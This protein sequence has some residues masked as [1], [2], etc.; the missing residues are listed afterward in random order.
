M[1]EPRAGLMVTT[2]VRLVRPLGEGGMGSVWVAEHTGLHT[3]VVVK[4]ISKEFA[5][6]EEA[7]TRFS[8]EA[9]AASQVK[10]PH[11]VQTLDHGVT[12]D[13]IA[14]IVMEH[15]EGHDLEAHMARGPMPAQEV[16]A[17]VQ[18]LARALEKAHAAGIVHRDI[19]P[20]NVFLCDAG[21]GG[22]FV[23]LLDFGIAKGGNMPKLDGGTKTGAMMGS[24]Y[25]MSPE[26]VVGSRELDHRT[27]LWSVG[28]MVYEA[29]TGVRPFDAETVGALAIRIHS[30]PL[31]L[32]SRVNAKLPEAFDHWFAHACARPPEER[33]ASAKEL[34][35]QLAAAL[36]GQVPNSVSFNKPG[37]RVELDFANA[38]TTLDA[39]LATDARLGLH[40]ANQTTPGAGRSIQK[41]LVGVAVVVIGFASAFVGIRQIRRDPGTGTAAT[42]AAPASAAT[43]NATA[44]PS[45]SPPPGAPADGTPPTTSAGATRPPGLPPA[46]PPVVAA[47][48]TPKATPSTSV[49]AAPTVAPPVRTA[50]PPPSSSGHDIY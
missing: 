3:E 2:N 47:K 15:L 35:D 28:V 29:L 1:P 5:S 9:A 42:S 12:P 44:P 48:K 6:N 33:F 24:P 34:A 43:E 23:K 7:L 39:Q 8:R 49:S 40:T 19:K 36:T 17:I 50:D 21:D 45:A 31:P 38:K 10:S 16:V 18:Q 30:E 22:L 37:G 27:D 26:Q 20:S 32:P 13:G 41:V 25:Y 11:V 14:Y 4:F 46:S